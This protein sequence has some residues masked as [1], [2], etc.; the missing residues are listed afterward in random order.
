MFPDGTLVVGEM[1]CGCCRGVIEGPSPCTA[2][3]S[4]LKEKCDLTVLDGEAH[5]VTDCREEIC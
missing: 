3:L 5:S 2:V 1:T 4:S